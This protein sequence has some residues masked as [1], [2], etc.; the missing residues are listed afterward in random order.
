ME[1]LIF[2]SSNN[3]RGELS[4]IDVSLGFSSSSLLVVQPVAKT[5]RK[6]KS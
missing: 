1:F 5:N 4:S 6:A 2:G 3:D